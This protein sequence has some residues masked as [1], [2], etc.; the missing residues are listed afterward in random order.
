MNLLLQS[1]FVVLPNWLTFLI[2]LILGIIQLIF[3]HLWILIYKIR[4]YQIQLCL[5][6][7]IELE[8]F[9]DELKRSWFQKSRLN[10]FINIINQ[11]Y[12]MIIMIKS[13]EN[14][15]FLYY[16]FCLCFPFVILVFSLRYK[17][18]ENCPCVSNFY[19]S[20]IQEQLM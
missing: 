5:Y 6:L 19:R 10:I 14:E 7:A 18:F 3:S 16:Q 11:A 2:I 4:V 17:L 15:V 1:L 20:D 12:A 9:I 8:Q 13:G